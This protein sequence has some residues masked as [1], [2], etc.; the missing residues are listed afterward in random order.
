MCLSDLV[1][2]DDQS[3]VVLRPQCNS[4]SFLNGN[5]LQS[6]IA[7]ACSCKLVLTPLVLLEA[8]LNPQR[9]DD[10]GV[11]D[12]DFLIRRPKENLRGECNAKNPSVNCDLF[13]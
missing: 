13:V 8:L 7:W 5:T 6:R 1:H 4:E 11:P 9:F 2:I 10:R 3:R 12:R